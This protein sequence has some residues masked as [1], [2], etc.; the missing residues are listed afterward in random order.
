MEP[1]KKFLSPK[2]KFEWNG[3]LDILFNRA[4]NQTVEAIQEG[5]KIFDLTRRT[6][7][8]PDW[9]KTGIGFWLLQKYCECT[10]TSP[11]C[12]QDG[13]RIVLA[14]SRFLSS[15]ERNYAPVEGEALGV[16]WSLEQTRF[17]TMGCSDLLVVV[18]HKP[19]EKSW[20]T[21]DWMK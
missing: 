21:G 6:A 9:S 16:A 13:W 4:K 5:V 20:V 11:G 7:L 12:C 19:L 15:A 2:V 10:K 8:M 3:E 14:G 1:F 17:F 18:D